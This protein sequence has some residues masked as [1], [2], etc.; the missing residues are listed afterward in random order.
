M[1]TV[2]HRTYRSP[3]LAPGPAYLDSS[4]LVAFAVSRDSFHGRAVQF[5]GDHQVARIE[6]QISVLGLDET[7]WRL[8]RGM[9]ARARNIPVRQLDLGKLVKQGPA[10]LAPH[11]PQLRQA[12]AYMTTWARLT[13][14]N[15]SPN[16][17]VDSWLD[18]LSDI[19]GLHDAQHLAVAQHTGAR[20]FVTTDRD[21]QQIRQ[22]PFALH[23]YRL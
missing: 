9:V 13:A 11:L 3:I 2:I 4:V 10:V 8:A 19:G 22:L 14:P 17:F 23:I 21:Y 15:C 12:V 20:S 6:L 5:V 16:Q 7:L 18:R 1:P